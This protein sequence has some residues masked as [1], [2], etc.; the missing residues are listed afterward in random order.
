L[1]ATGQFIREAVTRHEPVDVG[2]PLRPS[3]CLIEPQV[4][5]TEEAVVVDLDGLCNAPEAELD[6]I[7]DGEWLAVAARLATAIP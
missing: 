1:A 3:R 2:L 5:V 7:K 6:E 4:T